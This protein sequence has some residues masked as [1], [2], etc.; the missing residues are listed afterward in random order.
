M[1]VKNNYFWTG[2]M[3]RDK[4]LGT[5]TDFFIANGD[6]AQVRRVRRHRTVRFHFVDALLSFPD[7]D[8]FELEVTLLSDTLHSE[9]PSI[10][11][12]DSERLFH[13]L[14]RTMKRFL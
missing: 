14:W 13:M 10:T 2:Q 4:D 5:M 11:K 12:K 9:S 1:I 7:Y 8:D 3:A 6:I